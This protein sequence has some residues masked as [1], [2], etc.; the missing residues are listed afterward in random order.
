MKYQVLLIVLMLVL[1]GCSHE[2]SAESLK[3]PCQTDEKPT[4]RLGMSHQSVL[5]TI[6]E[7]GGQDITRS[8]AIQGPDGERPEDGLYWDLAQY[9]AILEIVA[10]DGLVVRINYWT[11]ADFSRSKNHREETRKIVES[12]T[13]EKQT[14]L[15]RVKQ[16]W[17]LSTPIV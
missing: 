5:E 13:F 10:K 14:K 4:I 17:T 16:V 11:S 12:V 6:R 8:M 1:A 15:L 2:R 3:Q 7:C 9:N